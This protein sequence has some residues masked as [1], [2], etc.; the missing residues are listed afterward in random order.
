MR[1]CECNLRIEWAEKECEYAVQPAE[2]VKN[3]KH[4]ASM[5]RHLVSAKKVNFLRRSY[6]V[7]L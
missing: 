5:L 4:L 7:S 2:A 3:R 6:E 1:P